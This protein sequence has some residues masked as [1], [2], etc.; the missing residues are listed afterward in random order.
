MIV[1]HPFYNTV[2]PVYWANRNSKKRYKVNQGGSSSSKTYSELQVI[3]EKLLH[4]P[5]KKATVTNAELPTLKAGALT[6]FKNIIYDTPLLYDSLENPDSVAGEFRYKN[7]SVIEFKSFDTFGKAKGPR[8]DYL[9]INEANNMAWDICNQLM[10]RTR[11]EI[12]IDFNADSKFWAHKNIV[13]GRPDKTDYFISNFTHNPFLGQDTIDDI[14][15]YYEQYL[16]TGRDY[17]LN[18]WKVYGMGL[19]GSVEGTIFSDNVFPI[20]YFPTVQKHGYGLDFGYTNDPTAL[21]E[22][23]V[24]FGN[25]YAREL[26]YETDLYSDKLADKMES[27]GVDKRLP[28]VADRADLSSIRT[29]RNRGF[30][31]IECDKWS[32]SVKDTIDFLLSK[33]INISRDS[34]NWWEEADNFKWK[35]DKDGGFINTPIDK[36]NHLWQ[37]LGYWGMKAYDHTSKPTTHT[38]PRRIVVAK[39]SS[40]D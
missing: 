2:T 34:V 20:D 15:F 10:I 30:N 31:V 1:K 27:I 13:E 32:G 23:G 25:I 28:I 4:N 24:K 12:Y 3:A 14:L 11:E 29:L 5:R 40:F 36:Y 37:A 39:K 21:C 19:T 38:K 16:L 35:K 9:F 6:D 8:R 17:W 33:N 18:K 26:L 22:C 7:K